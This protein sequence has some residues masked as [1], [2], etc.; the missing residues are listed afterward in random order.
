MQT[1]YQIIGDLISRPQG[2][3]CMEMIHH[4]GTT[5]PT[6]RMSDLR[7]LG[8]EITKTPVEGKNYSRFHGVAPKAKNPISAN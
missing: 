1:K 2:A 7:E 5:T 4:A 8:W 6:R 3:T